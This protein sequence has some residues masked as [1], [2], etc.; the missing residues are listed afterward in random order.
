MS[1]GD[2]RFSVATA[3]YQSLRRAV[4]YRWPAQERVGRRPA[5]QFTGIG[6]DTI[7]IE[8]VIYPH[9]RGGLYQVEQMREMAGQGKPQILTDGTGR[10]WGK[11]CIERIEETGSLCHAD[12]TPRKIEFR[13]SLGHYGEDK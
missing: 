12:G 11:W 1:L 10:V 3:A 4:E 7:E 6:N 13:V 9:Y 8:G 2:Y 5:R